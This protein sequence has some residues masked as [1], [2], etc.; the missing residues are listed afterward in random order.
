MNDPSMVDIQTL[1]SPPIVEA[2]LDV[3]VVFPKGVELERL[4]ALHELFQEAYPNKN[5]VRIVQFNV[6]QPLGQSPI[7]STL[8]HGVQGYR[9]LTEDGKQII[10]C[11]QNGFTFNRLAPYG[12]WEDFI[13]VARY[14]WESYRKAFPEAQIV[15][16]GVR[17]INSVLVPLV[18][19]KINLEDFFTVDLPGPKQHGFTYSNFMEHSVL[20]DPET[21]LGI[22][23]IFAQQPSNDPSK[24]PIIL[25]IDIFALGAR[26][27]EDDPTKMWETMRKLKN[28]IFFGSFTTRGLEL[29]K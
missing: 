23:W 7:T 20:E 14:A 28:R 22:N 2:L 11:R 15:R 9:F 5:E 19:G 10:Q 21:K 27:Q 29:F 26:A 1:N 24:L 16:I 25:D 17:Y 12:T 8:D 6:Q 13:A 4:A 3:Q 18:D